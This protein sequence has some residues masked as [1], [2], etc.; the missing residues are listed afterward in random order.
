[1]VE[2]VSQ[3]AQG[4]NTYEAMNIVFADGGIFD[5]LP[6]VSELDYYNTFKPDLE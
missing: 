5:Q 2:G 6:T 4:T 1:M 3:S